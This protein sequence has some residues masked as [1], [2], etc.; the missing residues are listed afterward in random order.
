M[1]VLGIGGLGYKDSAAALISDGR[2]VAAAAE[3]RFSGVKHEGGFP[4]RAVKFCLQRGGITL[5]DLA[6]VAV[7]NNPWLPMREKVLK[8]Y[9]E[10][11]FKSRTANVYNVFKDDGHR[12]VEYLKTLEDLRAHGLEVHE[13]SN[14]LSHKA[15]AFFASPYERAAILNVGGRGEVSTSGIGRGQDTSIDA[16]TVSRMPDSLGLLTALLADYIGYSDLDDEF[17]LIS[18]SF[19]GTPTFEPKMREVVQVAGDGSYKLNPEYFGYHQGRAYLSERF[20]EVFGP[21]RDPDL[22]LEDRHRD[23]AASLHAVVIDVVLQMARR[24]RER[25]GESNLCLG[26]G[27]VQNWA[28]VGQLCEAGIFEGIYVPPA[29]GDDGT[30]LGAALWLTHAQLGAPRTSPLLRADL[31][32][33]FSEDEIAEELERLK[34]KPSK[35]GDL[36]LAAADRINGGQIVG[37]FQGAAEFGPR[38]LGNRSILADPTHPATRARLAASVKARSEFHPFGLSVIAEAAGELFED[39]RESPF[40]ERTGRLREEVRG[41]LPAVAGIGGRARVQTVSRE[42]APLFHQLLKNVGSRTG[43][44]AV[45]NTSLNEPGRAMATSPREAIGSFYTTGLDAMALGPFVLSK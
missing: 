31:G 25:S 14:D 37:W 5:K 18:I 16:E 35:P 2:V 24:A 6:G 33:A 45:L 44:P 7:A 17:R 32:P 1:H 12:L 30:A 22:P 21:P 4:H 34:L 10:G 26:G 9:G 13:I 3:E 28:L 11:F 36:A 20:T 27:L 42:R 8:W 41:R 19:T 43:V 40:L 29:P 15:A 23:L 38:A 39:L